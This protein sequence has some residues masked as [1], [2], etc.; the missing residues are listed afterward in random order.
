MKKLLQ[1]AIALLIV[2]CSVGNY[3]KGQGQV[4]EY[5]D[6]EFWGASYNWSKCCK[7]GASGWYGMYPFMF[8]ADL[9]I[10]ID[11]KQYFYSS[12]YEKEYASESRLNNGLSNF[13][14]LFDFCGTVSW[15][16]P[17]IK[18]QAFSFGLGLGCLFSNDTIVNGYDKV[19]LSSYGG[20]SYWQERAIAENKFNG[21][22]I[23]RP[24]FK[25]MTP[26]IADQRNYYKNWYLVLGVAYNYVFCPT[27][28]LNGFQFSLGLQWPW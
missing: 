15:S 13:N 27:G 3:A 28:E 26:I 6:I 20:T 23:L 19:L 1:Y 16:T 12:K 11:K 25:W 2:I 9:G 10:N 7:V 17:Q 24:T 21:R 4:N 8:G 5:S 18:G 14:P 22:F